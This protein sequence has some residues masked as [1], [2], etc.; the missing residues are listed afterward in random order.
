[1]SHSKNKKTLI[2]NNG[3]FTSKK[4]FQVFTDLGYPIR[5]LDN[6]T[7]PAERSEILKWLKKTKGAILT[8]VS[9]LTTGFDEPTVQTVILNRATN[10]RTLDDRVLGRGAR[11]L[12]KQRRFISID[13]GEITGRFAEGNAP[14]D[15][16]AVLED[17][18]AYNESI[19]SHTGHEL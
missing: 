13:L 1:E 7:S 14:L 17:P 10:S 3:I 16:Q 2:F 6:Q 15:W 5:H 4:V 11:W 18:E 9:I 8:S 19:K 12:P